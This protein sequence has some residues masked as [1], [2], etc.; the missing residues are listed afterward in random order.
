MHNYSECQCTWSKANYTLTGSCEWLLTVILKWQMN[1]GKAYIVPH[2][3]LFPL[4]ESV[5]PFMLSC[6]HVYV[7]CIYTHLYI[8]VNAENSLISEKAGIGEGLQLHG[9]L[10]DFLPRLSFNDGPVDVLLQVDEPPV[11]AQRTMGRYVVV[12]HKVGVSWPIRTHDIVHVHSDGVA[13]FG[14]QLGGGRGWGGPGFTFS[15][16]IFSLKDDT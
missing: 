8:S 14:R 4:R 13:D 5:F 1:N 9:W 11:V 2:H 15:G 12:P 7:N 16:W 10:C 3:Y 6:M